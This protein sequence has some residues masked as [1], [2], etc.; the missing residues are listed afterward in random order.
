M[1]LLKGKTSVSLFPAENNRK[2]EI[3]IIAEGI[4]CVLETGTKLEIFDKRS[5]P[6]V[7]RYS[8]E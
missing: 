8:I 3:N 1:D 4:G 2:K 6:T 7:R 5:D